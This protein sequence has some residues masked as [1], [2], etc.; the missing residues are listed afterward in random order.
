MS[1]LFITSDTHFGHYNII[2]YCNRPFKD[3]NHMDETLIRNWNERIKPNDSVIFAGD[4]SFKNS[5]GGKEGEGSKINTSFDYLKRLNG[6]LVMLKGN[7]DK[8]NGINTHINSL[9]VGF[10]KKIFHIQHRPPHN[11]ESIIGADIVLCGHVHEKWKVKLYEFDE[12]KIPVINVS[13][14]VW[15]FKPIKFTEITYLVDKIEKGEVSFN[16]R[17]LGLEPNNGGSTPSTSAIEGF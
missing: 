7:H 15:G 12:I 1:M 14:D 10:G 4:F 8:N 3:L 16:G 11:K 17:T 9:R 2:N 6:K 13:V 5:S